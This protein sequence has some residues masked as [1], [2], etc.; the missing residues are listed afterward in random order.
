MVLSDLTPARAWGFN[1]SDNTEPFEPVNRVILR[2]AGQALSCGLAPARDCR[3]QLRKLLIVNSNRLP[4]SSPPA[5]REAIGQPAPI[6]PDCSRSD[7]AGNAVRGCA[8]PP[9]PACSA[10]PGAALCASPRAL[11]LTPTHGDANKLAARFAAP[12]GSGGRVATATVPQPSGN[13]QHIENAALFSTVAELQALASRHAHAGMHLPARACRGLS[14]AATLQPLQI[15]YV[16]QW[17]RGCSVVA[18]RLRL[19]PA[20][21]QAGNEAC[22]AAGS[23]ILAGRY[24]RRVLDVACS[25]VKEARV[26]LTFGDFGAARISGRRVGHLDL[27]AMGTSSASGRNGGFPR[28]CGAGCGRV[29]RVMLEGCAQVPGNAGISCLRRQPFRLRA[30][31]ALGAPIGSEAPPL[32]PSRARQSPCTLAAAIFPIWNGF[33]SPAPILRFAPRLEKP[34]Q[35]WGGSIGSGCGMIR[36]QSATRRSGRG[37]MLAGKPRRF[38]DGSAGVACV[39]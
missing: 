37:V 19:Q 22:R 25:G 12:A 17:V 18:A 26:A 3:D 13:L 14:K 38:C 9:R 30:S 6:A 36:G 8:L 4:F 16:E 10:V 2:T 35:G 31:A 29:G 39:N 7:A 5:P 34:R 27:G 21:D 24:P 15:R 20:I 32:P 28:V 23:N 33:S 1:G 11:R